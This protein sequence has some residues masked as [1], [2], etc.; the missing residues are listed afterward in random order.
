MLRVSYLFPI[1]CFLLLNQFRHK[2]LVALGSSERLLAQLVRDGLGVGTLKVLS[3]LVTLLFTILLARGLG[4]RGFGEYAFVIAIITTLSIPVAPAFMQLA[5]RETAVMHERGDLG[6]IWAFL[7][8]ANYSVLWSSIILI[9]AAGSLAFLFS[10]SI[11]DNWWVKLLVGL[12]GLPLLGLS[13]V[14][15]G[16]LTGL[17]KV[18]KGQVSDLLIRP[19]MSLLLVAGLLLLGFLTPLSALVAYFLGAIAAFTT[20]KVLLE[21]TLPKR[22]GPELPRT[23]VVQKH[24]WQRAWTGFTLSIGAGALNMEIGILFLGWLSTEEQIAAMQVAMRVSMLVALP[25]MIANHVISPH[26][27]QA[28]SSMNKAKLQGISRY[29]SRVAVV[30]ALPIAMPLI[31]FGHPILS[32]AFGVE[33]ADSGSFPLAILV[34]AQ[35]VNSFCGPVGKLLVMSGYE[36]QTMLGQTIGL[37]VVVSAGFLLIPKYGATGAA[38]AASLGIC[39]WNVVLATSVSKILDIRPTAA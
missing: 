21:R 30:V 3:L 4:P 6:R 32:L 24:H 25:L 26:I 1:G 15:A 11:R 39:M 31:F 12:I 8:W 27:A 29:T 16:A 22:L 28:H 35:L 36:L 23:D 5:I 14:R 34:C 17:G 38:T 10:D 20:T 18:V 19:V 13:A 37:V 2:R 33:Y 9:A 7:H